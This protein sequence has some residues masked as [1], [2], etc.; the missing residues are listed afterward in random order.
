MISHKNTAMKFYAELSAPIAQRIVGDILLAKAN[1]KPHRLLIIGTGMIGREHMRV[2]S[3]LGRCCLHGIYDKHEA[4]M[5]EAEADLRSYL[6]TH[7]Q[8]SPAAQ[9]PSSNASSSLKRYAD[10]A[11]ACADEDVD[12]FM[13]CT[14]NFTHFEIFQQ[15]LK[16]GKPIFIEKPMATNL[17]DAREMMKLIGSYGS[18]VQLGMQ[19]RYKSQY[20]DAFHEVKIQQALGDIKTISMSEYRPPFLD[21]VEQ[22]NKFN[23]NSGGTLVEKCCHYF[24]LLNLMADSEPARVFASG[25]QAVNFLDF[26]YQG[27]KSDID[28]HAFV[29]IDYKNGVRASFTL[30]MFSQELYEELIVSGEKGRIKATESSSFKSGNSSTATLMVEVDGHPAYDPVEVTYPEIIERSGHHGATF[31]EHIAFA[32]QLDGIDVDSATPLQG[33]RAMLLASAAQES[34]RRGAPVEID[35]YNVEHGLDKF[36]K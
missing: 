21:K 10:L 2:I 23:C 20:R 3:L 16:T 34:M 18:F 30:N 13:V 27:K 8:A 33:L 28:D 5:D 25:G 6:S 32:D 12:A 22:W 17:D 15:L 4:S 35:A 29:I 11:S 7:L 24:D 9:P 36:F 14:P 1:P 26:E 31:F 19:Y